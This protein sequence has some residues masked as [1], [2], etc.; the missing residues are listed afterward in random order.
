MELIT[1]TKGTPHVTSMQHRSIFEGIIGTESYIL[2]KGGLLEPELGAGNTIQ[3]AS[4]LLCHHGSISEVAPNTYDEVTISNGSQ[5]MQ[6][7]DLIVARYTKDPE[8]QVESMSWAVIQGTPAESNPVVPSYESGNMQDGDLTDDCPVFSV[9]LDGIQIV[10]I[11]KLLPVLE[12]NLATDNVDE[13]WVTLS[14]TGNYQAIAAK[15]PKVRKIGKWVE[16]T[17]GVRNTVNRI[18]GSTEETT[19]GLTLPLE[20][21][22]SEMVVNEGTTSIEQTY[23]F[24]VNVDGTLTA[25][26]AISPGSEGYTSIQPNTAVFFHAVYITDH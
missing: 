20:Y 15:P 1:G 25:S 5:G 8:T 4:G 22:P 2:K 24:R 7:I 21:R 13:G 18:A 19:I 10:G 11:S 16:V 14:P 6:R 3:I 23:Q 12:I 17:G 26:R 9:E